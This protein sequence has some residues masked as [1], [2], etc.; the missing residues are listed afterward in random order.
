MVSWYGPLIT[1]P[2]AWLSGG[3][4]AL[5][6]MKRRAW[7]LHLIEKARRTV[8]DTNGLD[9]W[10]LEYGFKWRKDRVNC[11]SRPWLTASRMCGDCEDFALLSW[12]ILKGKKRCVMAICHGRK[13]GKKSGHAILLV[14]EAGLWLV[15]SN[16]RRGK[17]FDFME[18]A[19]ESVY[20]KETVDYFFVE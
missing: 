7:G 15:M 14:R 20:G 8:H 13:D 5:F 11:Y 12:E 4:E 10:Y 6:N 18:D 19:A 1:R 17:A 9:E 2:Y 3:L 16:M